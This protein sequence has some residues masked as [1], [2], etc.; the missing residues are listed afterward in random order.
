[1]Q[2]A[3]KVELEMWL[4]ELLIEQ[5]QVVAPRPLVMGDKEGEGERTEVQPP[6][7]P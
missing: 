1:L 2:G 6:S 7:A 4:D 5:F 3:F